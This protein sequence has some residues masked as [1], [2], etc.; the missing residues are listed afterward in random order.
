MTVRIAIFGTSWWADSMYLPALASLPEAE[1][2]AVCGRRQAPAAELADRWSIPAFFTDS[3]ELFR[4]A[5]P[6]AVIIATANDSH[7]AIAMEAIEAGVAVLCEKPLGRTLAEAEEMAAAAEAAD[8]TTMVPFTYRYMPTNQYVKRLLDEGFV[9][10]P[11]HLNLR[12][13]TDYARDST[14]TW[15]FDEAIAGSG[16]LGDLATHWFHLARWFLGDIVEVGAMTSHHR[17]RD[18]RPD[19][20]DYVRSEDAANVNVRFASGA[21]GVL[22]V[23]AAC[24]EATDFGQTH[25]LEI[26]GEAGTLASR[27]DWDAEQTVWGLP[28]GERGP[29][30]RLD[31]PA[32]FT[33]GLR[34]ET[35]HD[36]YRDVFRESPVMTR[37]FVKAVAEN[38]PC[39]P[40]FAEGLAVQ[41]VLDAAIRSAADRGRRHAI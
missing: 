25:H 38:R 8:I 5:R 33:A 32:E 17:P 4:E 15:R 3:G 22:Q 35:V 18:P 7:H 24:S 6:D 2:V 30:R 29:L 16:V 36:T 40:D 20:S 26:I 14:Y 39:E 10:R 41:R 1:V 31:I 13:F 9:G 11:Y 19:G 23:S 34:T 28:A 21:D 27:I 12:Y 37:A